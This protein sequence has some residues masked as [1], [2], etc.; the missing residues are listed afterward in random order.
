MELANAMLDDQ[1]VAGLPEVPAGQYVLLAVTDTGTGMPPDVVERAF[2]PFFTTKPEGQGTGLGLAMVNTFASRSGGCIHIESK[3]GSGT[4]IEIILPRAPIDS[5][6]DDETAAPT[7]DPGLHG[8]A[9]LLLVDDDDQ[10]RQVT[11]TFLRELGYH[12]LEASN[13]E[14]ATAL[15]HTLPRLDLLVTDEDMPGASGRTL[16]TRLRGD[17]PGLPVLFLTGTAP[18][19]KL[20]GEAVLRKPFQFVALGAAVLERLGR[21]TP[22]GGAGDRLLKRLKTPALRQLYLNWQT[23][24]AD[25]VT[26]PSLSSLDP[27]RFGLGPHSFTAAIENE[28][29]VG[30]RFLSVGSALTTRLGR[31][32]EGVAIAGTPESEE[33]LGELH[34]TYRRCARNLS[35]VYQAARLD[36]GDGSPLHLERL[37]LPLSENARTVTHLVGIALFSEP[38]GVGK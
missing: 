19:A 13:V 14:T 10:F 24:K 23:A 18:L 38:N 27:A 28:D 9:T 2:E 6:V 3:P 32:L 11:A 12:V 5:V 26:L 35:P 15:V 25:G 29:P 1:Y 8:D 4:M 16:V 36:F 33:I 7:P 37:V 34:A 17:W 20:A 22:P 30:F 31:R 21:W